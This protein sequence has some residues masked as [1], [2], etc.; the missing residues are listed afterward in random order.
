MNPA[1][2]RWLLPLHRWT[3]LTLGLLLVFLAIT[4]IALEF[5]DQLHGLAEPAAMQPQACSAKPLPLDEQVAAARAAHA[6]GKLEVVMVGEYENGPTMV[7]F[8]DDAALYVDPCSGHV[9]MQQARWGG[10][11]GRVEQLHRFRFLQDAELANAITGGSAALLSVLLV[12]FGLVLWWPARGTSLKSAAKL[13]PH[14]KGRAFEL[15]VHRVAGAWGSVLLLGVALSSLPLAFPAVRN[16]MAAAIGSTVK[17]PKIKVAPP[18]AGAKPLSAGVLW[19]RA[20]AVL[21]RPGK[22]VITLPKKAGRPVEIYALEADAPHGEAR[23]Y[24]YLDPTTGAVLRADPYRASPLGNRM[25]RTIAAI[26]AGEF[27]ALLQWLQFAGTLALPVLAWTGIASWLRSRR[28]AKQAGGEPIAMKVVAVRDE[29]ADIRS[30]ELARA[31]GGKLPRFAAGAHIDL[32]IAP[33]LLRPYSLCGD[34]G[35]RG[36]WQ[37]AV[38]RTAD[39]RGGSRTVHEQFQPG[40]ECKVRGPRNHFPLVATASH[41]VLMAGGIGITPMLA[42]ARALQAQNAS[43]ELHYFVQGPGHTAFADVLQQ[44]RFAGRVRVHAGLQREALRGCV[45]SLLAHPQA[46]HHLYICGPS[47]FMD[48]VRSAAA[49]W[50]ADC[51]HSESFRA[52]PSAQN[53][54]REAFELHLQRSGHQ[55]TVPAER[56]IAEVL[57]AH[58]VP[59]T[60]SCA[61]GVCGTCT[62]RVLGGECDHRD[63]FLS[64]Q[65]RAAGDRILVCVSRARSGT[66]VLDL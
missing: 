35:H 29:A 61:E 45:Q 15:N 37:I 58:G 8:T 60:T 13:R 44:P 46:G 26:H 31:D 7:R 20:Q 5:R 55:L 6:T 47:G 51:V 18:A 32:E 24:V 65:E 50:P 27:G 10:F 64:P 34:P 49:A 62:T 2:R 41:H 30:Y 28:R 52:D 56:S 36:S 59:V 53:G 17:E 40:T 19:D 16:V 12:G 1:M 57:G 23:S 66:L 33:G 9:V 54:P 43:F 4:G 48:C 63:S 42:M 21:D 22:A 14:L 39:S 25:Y 11:F 38:K 3:G